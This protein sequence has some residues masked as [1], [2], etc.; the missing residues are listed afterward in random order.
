MAEAGL[1]EGACW[2]C[3]NDNSKIC[4][5]EGCP[6][7]YGCARKNGW[8]MGQPTPRGCVTIEHRDGLPPEWKRRRTQIEDVIRHA[9]SD[10]SDLQTFDDPKAD[11]ITRTEFIA[12]AVL[13]VVSMWERS[14]AQ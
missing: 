8:E 6:N 1:D 10:Y 13:A 12:E 2:R 14:E 9:Q 7:S 11:E 3:C 4:P 5:P